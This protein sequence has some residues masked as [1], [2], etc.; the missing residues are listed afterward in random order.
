MLCINKEGHII[1]PTPK[2]FDVVYKALGYVPYTPAEKPI[3]ETSAAEETPIEEAPK[4]RRSA[5]KK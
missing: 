5:K 1:D 3:G 4:P 2:A